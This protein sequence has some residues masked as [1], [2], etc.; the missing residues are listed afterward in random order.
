[1]V[2]N[3]RN[4]MKKLFPVFG[5]LFAVMAGL[6]YSSVADNKWSLDQN[7]FQLLSNLVENRI[8]IGDLVDFSFVL[9]A[10]EEIVDDVLI[11]E[12]SA[13][14]NGFSSLLF[15]GVPEVETSD[16]TV[17]YA[18]Y[19]S[20]Y[21]AVFEGI[22]YDSYIFDFGTIS[23]KVGDTITFVFEM[24][25]ADNALY[26]EG[27][28]YWMGVGVE[29]DHSQSI[30]VNDIAFQLAPKPGAGGEQLMYFDLS[31]NIPTYTKGASQSSYITMID[32]FLSLGFRMFISLKDT[33]DDLCICGLRPFDM[34]ESFIGCNNAG[35]PP[36]ATHFQPPF[37]DTKCKKEFEIDFGV[38]TKLNIPFADAYDEVTMEII[39]CSSGTATGE[40][41]MDVT[42]D[43]SAGSVGHNL[44]TTLNFIESPIAELTTFP[45]ELDILF[46]NVTKGQDLSIRA[47]I[48]PSP[49]D[50]ST[51]YQ[52]R[53]ILKIQGCTTPNP[54]RE[55]EPRMIMKERNIE[56]LEEINF[57]NES[58]TLIAEYDK[59]MVTRKHHSLYTDQKYFDFAID[60]KGVFDVDLEECPNL[61]ITSEIILVRSGSQEFSQCLETF[62]MNSEASSF[63]VCEHPT[64]DILDILDQDNPGLALNSGS[65]AAVSFAITMNYTCSGTILGD[66]A[67]AAE[68]IQQGYNFPSLM[69]IEK[70]RLTHVGDNFPGLQRRM[71]DPNPDYERKNYITTPNYLL[72]VTQGSLKLGDVDYLGVNT[73][74]MYDRRIVFTAEFYLLNDPLLDASWYHD[75]TFFVS[76]GVE[77]FWFQTLEL[78]IFYDVNSSLLVFPDFGDNLGMFVNESVDLLSLEEFF[79]YPKTAAILDL[80][81]LWDHEEQILAWRM[82][83]YISSHPDYNRMLIALY[84]PDP[85]SYLAWEDI[86]INPGKNIFLQELTD[87][88]G[89]T[90][91]TY[92]NPGDLKYVWAASNL[93]SYKNETKADDQL[94]VII[95]IRVIGDSPSPPTAPNPA[96]SLCHI[97]YITLES[98]I[99]ADSNQFQ[100][101]GVNG[102]STM[103]T[104]NENQPLM[105]F[106]NEVT[107]IPESGAGPV[108]FQ[109]Y[110][111]ARSSRKLNV[112]ISAEK[113]DVAAMCHPIV[114][115]LQ[116]M[117]VGE[118]IGAMQWNAFKT[119]DCASFENVDG[120]EVCNEII[121]EFGV[122]SNL[123]LNYENDPIQDRNK[124]EFTA[125]VGVDEHCPNGTQIRLRV[126]LYNIDERRS[127]TIEV[128][129]AF[130]DIFVSARNKPSP[131][132]EIFTRIHNYH[133]GK[134]LNE[135][136]NATS[137]IVKRFLIELYLDDDMTDHFTLNVESKMYSGA[138]V[139]PDD[140]GAAFTVIG[141]HLWELGSDIY[142]A[143]DLNNTMEIT[144]QS[145]L[146]DDAPPI[147]GFQ[148]NGGKLDLGVFTHIPNDRE[149]VKSI[150]Q[151]VREA[152]SN[153]VLIAVDIELQDERFIIEGTNTV[154]LSFTVEAIEHQLISTQFTTFNPLFVPNRKPIVWMNLTSY[155]LVPREALPGDRGIYMVELYHDCNS[156]A[157]A[158][159]F[160]VVIHMPDYADYVIT[161]WVNNIG[162]VAFDEDHRADSIQFSFHSI[163]KTE[164][165]RFNVTF[166]FAASHEYFTVARIYFTA[167]PMEHFYKKF[168]RDTDDRDANTLYSP[169][170]STELIQLFVQESSCDLLIDIHNLDMNNPCQFSASTYLDPIV[171]PLTESFLLSDKG[172]K[173]SNWGGQ[174]S[175]AQK[176]K[177]AL[178]DDYYLSRIY[179]NMNT[180][181]KKFKLRYS[182]DIEGQYWRKYE[183]LHVWREF[184][185]D[186]TYPSANHGHSHAVYRVGYF[187]IRVLTRLKWVEFIFTELLSPNSGISWRFELQG[188]KP[189]DSVAGD[190]IRACGLDQTE[191]VRPEFYT[192]GFL[193]D[194]DARALY[195]CE[196]NLMNDNIIDCVRMMIVNGRF[197]WTTMSKMIAGVIGYLVQ[198]E[199]QMFAIGRSQKTYLASSDVG[200][201]WI[202]V[203]T[204]DW[205][206]ARAQSSMKFKAVKVMPETLPL[207]AI[208]D[209][210]QDWR[211]LQDSWYGVERFRANNTGIYFQ[212]GSADPWRLIYNW[213]S[214]CCSA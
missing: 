176:F 63:D 45:C 43:V 127:S 60:F 123:N 19:G 158:R 164:Y 132:P 125:V 48:H 204:K 97:D 214:T 170:I 25:V 58:G 211:P 18:R 198:P 98:R 100:M 115:S 4:K 112:K 162:R 126:T 15:C 209:N 74:D 144:F 212:E 34:D 187:D 28:Q 17:S 21:D 161:D 149:S 210:S 183:E 70:L 147:M 103:A 154:Q 190:Y 24:L 153:A 37:N 72:S 7:S 94:E 120:I 157:E 150:D 86:Q 29:F 121:G 31:S 14:Y 177:V 160:K 186:D 39:M 38:L 82:A 200:N 47:T 88:S 79:P 163:Q 155:F 83:L 61:E 105:T 93:E 11:V 159:E 64:V 101:T 108:D 40:Y 102:G 151:V 90:H 23:A 208:N 193:A 196:K 13:S 124:L 202:T 130:Q 30:W 77:S 110:I 65:E 129:A 109:V 138:P 180:T 69:T 213:G 185:M 194:P 66:L 135:P 143:F 184:D 96:I 10:K 139:D 22:S 207:K 118:Y 117:S 36:F 46:N 142:G 140:G 16:K 54:V 6:A 55:I 107:E 76:R 119:T 84:I 156:T 201:N 56:F 173:S 85:P 165:L 50:T 168:Y 206:D 62:Q 167:L 106:Q 27:A 188:C 26:V 75:I 148:D 141:L 136:A 197:L 171:Y 32:P 99:C 137:G 95:H 53:Q 1:M 52:V 179:I 20:T 44:N 12:M 122:I 2:T 41:E 59:I 33:S 51:V 166:E 192:R 182:T 205:W 146:Y 152:K 203:P 128:G 92:S 9:T 195:V 8:T 89:V 134:I 67:L 172:F 116:L 189:S 87:T 35:F 68:L 111:Q 113:V 178:V 104:F 73:D 199:Y 174:Y 80:A 131:G 71:R 181:V 114:E 191:V 91:A 133:E 175:V 3:L 169:K 78:F 81:N 145:Y 57:W 42:L 49:Y 5:V